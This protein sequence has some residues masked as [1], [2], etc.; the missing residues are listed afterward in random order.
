MFFKVTFYVLKFRSS[1]DGGVRWETAYVLNGIK[2]QFV[3]KYAHQM[4]YKHD[5]S[6]ARTIIELF[7]IGQV[8]ACALRERPFN[9]KGGL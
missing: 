2:T 3:L 6:K 8:I 1:Q 4:Q 7:W 5:I 9:L